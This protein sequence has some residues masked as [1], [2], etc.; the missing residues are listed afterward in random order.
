MYG[1]PLH[2][3]YGPVIPVSI[4]ILFSLRF[5]TRTTVLCGLERAA[6]KAA[7]MLTRD[8]ACANFQ[9]IIRGCLVSEIIEKPN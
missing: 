4:L 6:F 5:L 8:M 3:K 7:K 2:P 9:K 1:L